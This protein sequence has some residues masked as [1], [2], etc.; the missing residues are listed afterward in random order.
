MTELV[1]G[2]DGEQIAVRVD[3]ELHVTLVEQPTGGA[4]WLAPDAPEGAGN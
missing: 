3:D 2:Y 4:R 1:P